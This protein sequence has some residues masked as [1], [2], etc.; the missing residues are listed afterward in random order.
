MK[1]FVA[2]DVQNLWY[3][4]REGFGR[5]YRVNFK[6]L[7][8]T[9]IDLLP[10]GCDV[11]ATAYVVVSPKHNNTAFTTMLESVGFRTKVR[12]LRYDSSGNGSIAK[13]DWDLGIAV[14]AM[15]HAYEGTDTFML[16]SGK[17]DYSYLCKTLR[18]LGQDVKI[19]T[20]EHGQSNRLVRTA[21]SVHLL[22][23]RNVYD[24]K[25]A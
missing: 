14:D 9:I 17:G 10:D 12:H 24:T 23:Q 18:E 2:I 15:Q 25:S 3:G 5:N 8:R 4:A 22:D 16:V 19:L 1:A 7:Q 11:S 21:N 20:F 13:S 6:S